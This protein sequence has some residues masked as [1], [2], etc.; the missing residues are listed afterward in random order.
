MARYGI[1]VEKR[2]GVAIPDL[3]A[4]AKETGKS[5]ALA[6]ALWQTGV[7][8]ARILAAMVDTPATLTEQQM[9]DWVC[10]FDSWDVCDQVCMN[11]FEKS[12]LAWHKAREWAQR[13]EIFVKRAAFALLACLAWHSKMAADDQFMAM[14]PVIE[15][16]A[17]DSRPIVKKAVSWALRSIGKRNPNL[18]AA[19]VALAGQL[20][21]APTASARWIAGDV[22]RDLASGAVQRKLAKIAAR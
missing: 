21:N 1:N 8:D 9:D 16:G 2:L 5:H 10:G 11:L 14:L 15:A 3:R 22:L 6:L 7:A 13:E 4:L 19:A 18:H 12:P 17:T 20:K